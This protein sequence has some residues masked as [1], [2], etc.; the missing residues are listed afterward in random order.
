MFCRFLLDAFP[1]VTRAAAAAHRAAVAAGQL[2][3]TLGTIANPRFLPDRERIRQRVKKL[4]RPKLL[5]ANEERGL[6]EFI[7]QRL[8]SADRPDGCIIFYQPLEC[9]CMEA[10]VD[11]EA[12]IARLK[13]QARRDIIEA[14]STEPAPAPGRKKRG[15]A[16]QSSQKKSA[17][18]AWVQRYADQVAERG[19]DAVL[20]EASASIETTERE[21]LNKDEEVGLLYCT[22]VIIIIIIFVYFSFL[23]FV[24][25][26]IILYFCFVIFFIFF[27]SSHHLFRLEGLGARRTQPGQ[28]APTLPRR[29][30]RPVQAICVGHHGALAA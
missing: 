22:A 3:D 9:M 4:S 13:D 26:A 19:I 16:S 27:F 1:P 28:Q 29:L 10:D 20:A 17:P 15:R 7:Q 6:P 25:I 24:F 21:K 14:A 30:W 12:R 23:F 8:F 18:S 11:G 5:H 2:G